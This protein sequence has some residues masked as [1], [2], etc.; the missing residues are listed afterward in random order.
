MM[1]DKAIKKV[2]GNFLYQLEKSK[3]KFNLGRF[4]STYKEQ[5]FII[6]GLDWTFLMAIN[7]FSNEEE[8]FTLYMW[9][10][11]TRHAVKLQQ[12]SMRDESI[13]YIL[14]Q[15]VIDPDMTRMVNQVKLIKKKPDV[16]TYL[17]ECK[18]NIQPPTRKVIKQWFNN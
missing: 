12:P 7:A 2:F 8:V 10:N 14:D 15:P 1:T 3:I 13:T 11:T 9:P 17:S 4:N 6:P 5:H 16:Y 18:V